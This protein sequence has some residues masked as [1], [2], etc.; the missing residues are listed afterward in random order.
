[1]NLSSTPT[2]SGHF[3]SQR[4]DHFNLSPSIRNNPPQISLYGQISQILDTSFSPIYSYF[5]E[6]QS[7]LPIGGFAP[8]T[9]SE[10]AETVV[11]G[12]IHG[13][14]IG[15]FDNLY[16]AGLIDETFQWKGNSKTLIQ[17]GDVI[18]RGY[19]SEAVWNF[20]GII[21]EQAK[22]SSG[23]VV[24]LIGNHEL[25]VLE[26]YYGYA[27][28]V[29]VDPETFSEQIKKDILED[30]VHLAYTD[31]KRLFLHAGMRTEIRNL[32]IREIMQKRECNS[33]D[34]YVEDIVEHLNELLV[35]AVR[36]EDYSH[37][38]FHIGKSR[39]GE[40]E[41]GGVV[42][43]D[44]SQ[45]A[46]SERA[47]DIPQVVGHNP[48]RH[49]SEPPIRITDSQ[50]LI[51]VDAGLNPIYGGNQAYVIFNRSDITVR[52]KNREQDIWI[53]QIA[54]DVLRRTPSD[55]SLMSDS[56]T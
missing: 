55:F 6:K 3:Y 1:M 31:G 25:M 28:Q 47:S 42:W 17:L 26:G 56:V 49:S 37:P 29:I 52:V 39:R 12:D 19:F 53:E 40:H 24:R 22:E 21:Q 48:P 18:D 10:L 36:E 13:E 45:I 54:R 33:T 51:E 35:K 20:L 43:E 15:F 44:F 34:V 38:I 14:L 8:S 30:K 4:V 23:K 11:F 32:L 7:P 9:R 41:I 50:R 5:F 2:L 27:A 16:N 46:S